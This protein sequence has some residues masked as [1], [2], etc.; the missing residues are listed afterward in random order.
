MPN[1]H[2]LSFSN[3]HVISVLLFLIIILKKRGTSL[4]IVHP[5]GADPLPR[6][7]FFIII[8]I[9]F[10]CWVISH[11]LQV[12]L[13]NLCIIFYYDFTFSGLIRCSTHLE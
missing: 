7:L 2:V 12:K 9:F 8:T 10:N 3:Y 13:L 11:P 5:Q 1:H 4:K 6:R